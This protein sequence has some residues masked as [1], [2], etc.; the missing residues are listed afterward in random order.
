MVLTNGMKICKILIT[1]YH[2]FYNK[3]KAMLL[4]LKMYKDEKIVCRKI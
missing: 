3:V 1:C 4:F 2:K